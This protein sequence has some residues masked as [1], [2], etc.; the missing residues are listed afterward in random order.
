MSEQQNNKIK[1]LQEELSSLQS[2]LSQREK[3]KDKMK[4]W[5]GNGTVKESK[6]NNDALW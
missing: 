4:Q 3:E 6:Y 2:S 5:V 1:I